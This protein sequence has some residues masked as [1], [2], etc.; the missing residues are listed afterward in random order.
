MTPKG[1]SKINILYVTC[2]LMHCTYLLSF[3]LF[4]SH[5]VGYY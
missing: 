4:N 2:T 1:Q 3:E 5:L